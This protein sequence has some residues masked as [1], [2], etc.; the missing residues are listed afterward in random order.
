MSIRFPIL[1]MNWILA[2]VFLAGSLQAEIILVGGFFSG[3]VDRVNATTGAVTLF[4]QIGS[5]T[6][7]FPGISGLAY[8][9]ISN[10]LLYTSPSPRDS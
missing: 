7:P 9:P 3:N 1:A 2:V 10:C 4:S 6:D 5:A 8:N